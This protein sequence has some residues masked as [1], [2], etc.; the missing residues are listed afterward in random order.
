MMSEATALGDIVQ[1]VVVSAVALGALV[2][3]LRRVLG[4]FETRPVSQRGP[5]QATGAA[6]ACGHCDRHGQE[7]APSR[8]D[9]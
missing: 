3:V 4:V 8:G 5:G 1:H 2:V 9:W 6:P 7:T